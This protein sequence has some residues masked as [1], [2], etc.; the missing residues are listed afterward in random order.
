[1]SYGLEFYGTNNQL[2]FDTLNFNGKSTLVVENG[3]PLATGPII[4]VSMFL[5][6]L[7]YLQE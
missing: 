4:V 7:F 1:M 3:H 2:I 5:V 6:M